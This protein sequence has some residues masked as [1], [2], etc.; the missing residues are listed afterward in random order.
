MRPRRRAL[1]RGAHPSPQEAR[2]LQSSAPTKMACEAR[3]D[4]MSHPKS[5]LP[6]RCSSGS[7]APLLR[8]V[9]RSAWK[10]LSC[11]NSVE[12]RLAGADPA[13]AARSVRD[14]HRPGPSLGTSGLQQ[15]SRPRSSDVQ[16]CLVRGLSQ[17]YTRS[18]PFEFDICEPRASESPLRQL[19]NDRSGGSWWG[20]SRTLDVDAAGNKTSS[21]YHAHI[22]F[23]SLPS[24]SFCALFSRCAS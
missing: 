23:L 2:A 9:V 22:A 18:A 16:Y 10:F 11:A 5:A 7:I 13:T 19:L 14:S 21:F 20:E 8:T 24:S 17:N 3:H 12:Q 4:A 6:S 1:L 15:L